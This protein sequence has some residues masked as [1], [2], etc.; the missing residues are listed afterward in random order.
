VSIAVTP[1][2]IGPAPSTYLFV[3]GHRPDLIAKARRSA[4]DAVVIDLEDAVAPEQRPAARVATAAVLAEHAE[5]LDMESA[6]TS[7][8]QLWVR[9]NAAGSA[10]GRPTWRSSGNYSPTPGCPR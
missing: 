2:S 10:E 9:V 4:A 8:Q 6:P 5:L 1:T 3:P 7:A